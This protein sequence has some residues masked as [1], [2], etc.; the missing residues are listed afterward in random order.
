MR[1]Y[2]KQTVFTLLGIKATNNKRSSFIDHSN[3]MRRIFEIEQEHL[4]FVKS[5]E[6]EIEEIS[7]KL[8]VSENMKAD[9]E[10]KNNILAKEICE[11]SANK[12][13]VNNLNKD[14]IYEKSVELNNL[15][16][17]FEEKVEEFDKTKI[18]IGKDLKK[19][20]HDIEKLNVILN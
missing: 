4:E 3:N 18:S 12:L 20:I 11:L 8:S 10:I 2:F 19:Y 7:K 16:K 6:I 15:K 17:H 5:V 14:S 1:D 13:F 9:L